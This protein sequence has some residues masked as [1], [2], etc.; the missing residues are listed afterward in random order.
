MQNDAK[1][2]ESARPTAII[3]GASS[4]IGEATA[5]ALAHAGYDLA[6]IARRRDLLDLC[7]KQVEEIGT[8]AYPIVADLADEVQTDEAVRE[9]CASLGTMRAIRPAQRS[10]NSAGSRCGTSSTSTCFPRCS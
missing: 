8:N 1:T 7:A 5:R 9:A 6:L 4:G 3:T 10:S 2:T